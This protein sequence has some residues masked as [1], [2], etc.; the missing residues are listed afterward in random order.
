M[1]GGGGPGEIDVAWADGDAD[2]GAVVELLHCRGSGEGAQRAQVRPLEDVR[3][4][5]GDLFWRQ[6]P[7]GGDALEVGGCLG[8][9]V[10]EVV[11]E[12]AS[13]QWGTLEE[14]DD[15]IEVGLAEP[16]QVGR[17]DDGSLL[18]EARRIGWHRA[19][20]DAADLSVVGAVGD[21]A[22]QL[23]S[24]MDGA[25][26]SDVGEVGSAEGRVVGDQH[27]TGAEGVSGSALPHADPEGTEVN[28]D[29]RGTHHQRSVGIE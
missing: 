23:T 20:C 16:E 3:H 10:G 24:C 14:L 11:A 8:M 1:D 27:V 13:G 6:R 29:V 15:G 21:I 18:G 12:L 19:G 22:D 7:D 28:R 25:D 26:D 5:G 17:G 4:V 2:L 9:Q